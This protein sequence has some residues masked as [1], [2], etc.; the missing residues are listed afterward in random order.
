MKRMTEKLTTTKKDVDNLKNIF[1]Q[2]AN[3]S[4]FSKNY[5]LKI[6][7]FSFIV[8]TVTCFV[9][10]ENEWRNHILHISQSTLVAGILG[11]MMQGFEEK[12]K[13]RYKEQ[14]DDL[15]Q[16]TSTDTTPVPT[17]NDPQKIAKGKVIPP[18]NDGAKTMV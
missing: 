13:R 2:D 6:W 5:C 11:W 7:M 14:V 17:P 8:G 9:P 10:Q 3:N 15:F 18:I 16:N 4:R 12:R 1:E